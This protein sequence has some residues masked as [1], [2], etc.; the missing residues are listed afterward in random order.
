MCKLCAFAAR[1][2]RV[3]QDSLVFDLSQF[4]GAVEAKPLTKRSQEQPQP[5]LQQDSS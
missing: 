3:R 5:N 1:Y 2:V 4:V